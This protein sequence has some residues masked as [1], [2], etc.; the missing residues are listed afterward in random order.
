MT[1][2]GG[3]KRN[4]KDLKVRHTTS[5]CVVWNSLKTLLITK[6]I[7]NAMWMT[8]ISLRP[9]LGDFPLQAR[10]E[11]R[12]CCYKNKTLYIKVDNRIF[13]IMEDRK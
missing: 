3:R 12:R 13:E 5:Y 6:N 10:A 7:L 1:I 11:G 9:S 4:Q 2:V 8:L